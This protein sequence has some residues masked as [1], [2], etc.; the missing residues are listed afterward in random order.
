MAEKPSRPLVQSNKPFDSSEH[1]YQFRA[2]EEH[3]PP[4]LAEHILYAKYHT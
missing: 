1:A 2:C 4:D 3:L